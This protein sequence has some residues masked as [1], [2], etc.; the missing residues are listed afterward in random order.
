MAETAP[1]GADGRIR[2]MWLMRTIDIAVF[3]KM[4]M[5]VLLDEESEALM[6]MVVVV[7]KNIR[8]TCVDCTTW[9][10]LKPTWRF[11]ETFRDDLHEAMKELM[12]G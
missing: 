11:R 7:C 3:L 10:V 8:C 1:K 5:D 4:W 6:N 2:F 9:S 12:D